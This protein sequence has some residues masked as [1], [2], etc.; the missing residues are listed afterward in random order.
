MS[1]RFALA[2]AQWSEIKKIRPLQF[3]EA[4]CGIVRVKLGK[5][6]VPVATV[7]SPQALPSPPP[8][9]SRPNQD[10]SPQTSR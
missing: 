8:E 7:T 4:T 2:E 9:A 6:T 5:Q 10:R 3:A 1:H